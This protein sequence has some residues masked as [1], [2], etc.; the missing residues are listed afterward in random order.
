M[1]A[2]KQPV[3]VLI[4][5]DHPIVRDGM[6]RLLEVERDFT[7]VAEADNGV[8]TVALTL[9]HKPDLLILDV[10]MPGRSGIDVLQDLKNAKLTT[11][12][13]I[14]TASIEDREIFQ[15]MQ[16][17]ARGIVLKD[18][19]PDL[20]LKSLRKVHEG[21]IWLEN[22]AITR[23]LEQFSHGGPPGGAESLLSPREREIVGLVAEGCRNREIGQKLFIAE[24]TVKIHLHNIYE[25]LG[26]S[27]RLEL[28]LFAIERKL[29]PEG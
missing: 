5:D 22:R 28:A 26:V 1:P 7:V 15:A 27:D 23:V 21:E 3:R 17:G 12:V 20:I 14:L 11:H 19:P 8:D 18:S 4:A 16:L 13:I 9:K 24:G 2:K 29:L 10:R 25:K 6:R